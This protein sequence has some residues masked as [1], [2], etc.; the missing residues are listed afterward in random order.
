LL[1]STDFLSELPNM[2][3]ESLRNYWY[4]LWTEADKHTQYN[5]IAHALVC[6]YARVCARAHK[7]THKATLALQFLVFRT[8]CPLNKKALNSINFL[9]KLMHSKWLFFY[10]DWVPLTINSR[11][12]DLLTIRLLSHVITYHRNVILVCTFGTGSRNDS[13]D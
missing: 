11:F 10:A 8:I 5:L 6:S 2:S 3:E 4:D 1:L 9:Q 13:K 12:L 7:H